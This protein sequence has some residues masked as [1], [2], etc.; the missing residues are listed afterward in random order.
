MNEP[1]AMELSSALKN[2]DEKPFRKFSLKSTAVSILLHVVFLVSAVYVVAMRWETR[3]EAAFAP[4][5]PQRPKLEP[6]KLE[7]KVK[8]QQLQKRSARPV[9]SPRLVSMSPSDMALPDIT[10]PNQSR[11]TA[12]RDFSKL[13]ASGN[14]SGIGGGLGDG[15]GGGGGTGFFGLKANG[16]HF[17][18][19]IDYSA[20]MKQGG[21]VRR[22]RQ[23]LTKS[24]NDLP[25]GV[26]VCIIMFSG[27]SWQAGED[28]NDIRSKWSQGKA[29]WQRKGGFEKPRWV[30]LTP[31]SK[32]SL[33]KDIQ[34]TPLTFGTDWM[35][36][37]EMAFKLTPQPSVIFFMT[38][39]APQVKN[40]AKV[41]AR[42]GELNTGRNT[43]IKA[44]AIGEPKISQYMKVLAGGSIGGEYKVVKP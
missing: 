8:V 11:K 44:I 43:A 5:P 14:G 31:G 33:I 9:L 18:Y 41:I 21:R 13:G 24:I 2:A 26:Q 35:P 28:A 19:I 32:K 36:G 3:P 17:C 16:T 38:D 4:P 6:K 27:P 20:S 37:F 29:G 23:E 40:E 25:F 12:K 42:A 10:K 7:M 22:M 15:M 34:E 39:G 1:V 30:T